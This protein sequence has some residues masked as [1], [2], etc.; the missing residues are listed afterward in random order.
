M[1]IKQIALVTMMIVNIYYLQA[2]DKSKLAPLKQYEWS[3][4]DFS[5]SVSTNGEIVAEE[6]VKLL[7]TSVNYQ[8]DPFTT[9]ISA[10]CFSVYPNPSFYIVKPTISLAVNRTGVFKV[11]LYNE[12]GKEL[13]RIFEGILEKNNKNMWEIDTKLNSGT[14]Y[15]KA[16]TK[17]FERVIKLVITP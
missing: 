11:N 1:K 5:N 13:V 15:I 6:D 7:L 3:W 12:T 14:Y 10:D 16:S 9:I 4:G 8:E 2:K 17:G